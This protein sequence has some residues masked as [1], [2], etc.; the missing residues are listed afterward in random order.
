MNRYKK[1]CVL[2]LEKEID[3][4]NNDKKHYSNYVIRLRYTAPLIRCLG[5]V[6]MMPD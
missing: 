5:I 3:R 4:I 2:Y 1:A 6:Q